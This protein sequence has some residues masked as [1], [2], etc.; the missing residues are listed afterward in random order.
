MISEFPSRLE[1][2]PRYRL[3]LQEEFVVHFQLNAGLG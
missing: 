2:R 3:F 1:F